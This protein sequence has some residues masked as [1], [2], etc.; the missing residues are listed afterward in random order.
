MSTSAFGVEHGGIAKRRGHDEPS[1]G[2]RVTAQ[3]APMGLHGVI[4]GRRGRKLHAVANE[5]G[6]ALLGAAGGVGLAALHGHAPKSKVGML[7]GGVGGVLGLDAGVHRAQH[8][9]HYKKQRGDRS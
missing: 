4:A 2:R 9:G 6:G 8:H 5:E 7:A 1:L 3:A